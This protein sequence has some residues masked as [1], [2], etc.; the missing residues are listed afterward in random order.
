M[1]KFNGWG[2]GHEAAQA[3]RAGE[4]INSSIEAKHGGTEQQFW[5]EAGEAGELGLDGILRAGQ[6]RQGSSI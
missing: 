4:K 1:A 3:R 2:R 6:T 5:V